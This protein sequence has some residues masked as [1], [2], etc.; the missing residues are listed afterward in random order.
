MEELLRISKGRVFQMVRTAT[1]KVR[2]PK[3]GTRGTDKKLESDERKVPDGT[4][5]FNDVWR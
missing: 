5:S 1:A 3:H 4:Q 2:E